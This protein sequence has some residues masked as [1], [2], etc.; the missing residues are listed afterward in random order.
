MNP[1]T[2]WTVLLWIGFSGVI[3]GISCAVGE[4]SA[5]RFPPFEQGR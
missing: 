4:W 2:F 5:A 3:I 1:R